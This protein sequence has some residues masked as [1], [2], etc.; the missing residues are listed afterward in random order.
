M[1]IFN[2]KKLAA[3][4]DELTLTTAKLEA[5]TKELADLNDALKTNYEQLTDYFRPKYINKY[6]KC[7]GMTITFQ[8]QS[9]LYQAG[10]LYFNAL[11]NDFVGKP[12]Q[13]KLE[14]TI[15]MLKKLKVITKDGF[16][17]NKPKKTDTAKPAKKTTK[18]TTKK[19]GDK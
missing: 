15:S 1:D 12:F 19:G 11:I 9:V 13:G 18:Q 10:T 17:G 4:Q 5:T 14:F 3:L 7:D 2:K 6:F 8:V 16:Y